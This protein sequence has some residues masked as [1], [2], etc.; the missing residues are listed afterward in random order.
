LR[1]ITVELSF[2]I[3]ADDSNLLTPEQVAVRLAISRLTAMKWLRPSKIPGH[4]LGRKT[5]RIDPA[6]LD[7]FLQR[8]TAARG[9]L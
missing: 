3:M 9:V 4:K 5:W 2:S 8:Q 1:R 7:A 6:D